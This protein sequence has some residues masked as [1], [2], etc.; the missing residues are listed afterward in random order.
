M[1]ER[2]CLLAF[3]ARTAVG[4]TAAAS[5]AAVR[6]GMAMFKQHPF[7]VDRKGQPMT[8]ARDHFLPAE[9][10]VLARMTE[11]ARSA[12]LE[13]LAALK[14]R[15]VRSLPPLSV[16]LGLPEHRPGLPASLTTDLS[17]GLQQAL[18]P[19]WPTRGIVASQH[20]HSAGTLALGS[21]LSR[22]RA[23]SD[24]LLLVGG[25]DSCL[26][27]ETLEWLDDNGQLHGPGNTWGFI[28]G[29]G[30]AFCLLASESTARRL[31]F[32]PSQ[33]I[34]S[35]GMAR[36]AN[37]INTDTVCLGAGLTDAVRQATDALPHGLPHGLRIDQAYCD[38]NG[39]P[40]RGDELGYT[41]VRTGERF[42]APSDFIT[43]A[44]C[45]G[46]IGAA[47]G[48]AFVVLAATAGLRGYAKG[49]RALAC[50]SS[51][52]GA[53]AAVLVEMNVPV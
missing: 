38:L 1:A 53:R 3:G 41:L 42:A 10:P 22:L 18:A 46:D 20:G 21:A 25:V 27:P 15:D 32:E 13:A 24:E 51:E 33:W 12:S 14:G 48:P 39:E 28:P 8:V 7:M 16:L 6:A 5:A 19:E 9:M 47:S 36:E 45:W 29:E 49:P 31:G 11:L 34:A 23:G 52:G 17:N 50:T 43:P 2:A 35:F 37:L 26:E 4:A 40:Y 44:D 30:A